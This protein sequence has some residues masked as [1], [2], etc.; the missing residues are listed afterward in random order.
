M[1]AQTLWIVCRTIARHLIEQAG[2]RGSTV[3]E[4]ARMPNALA[5]QQR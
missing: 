3:N 5:D 4:S 2:L 1:T